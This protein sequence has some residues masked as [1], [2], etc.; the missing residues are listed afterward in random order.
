MKNGECSMMHEMH[1]MMPGMR[2]RVEQSA[3]PKP[4][5]QKDETGHSS[6]HP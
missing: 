1:K 4:E 5:P 6:H 3:E 2:N